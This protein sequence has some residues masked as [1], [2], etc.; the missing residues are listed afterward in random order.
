VNCGSTD[1]FPRRRLIKLV[2]MV[3]FL[4]AAVVFGFW[5]YERATEL[6]MAEEKAKAVGERVF[7]VGVAEE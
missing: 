7:E 1:P 6:K 2:M 4:I 3:A 5:F